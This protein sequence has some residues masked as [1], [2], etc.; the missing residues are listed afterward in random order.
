[1]IQTYVVLRN[2]FQR[3]EEE[4][5]CLE[6]YYC[7]NF[8]M[9]MSSILLTLP[10]LLKP[11]IR[12]SAHLHIFKYLKKGFDVCEINCPLHFSNRRNLY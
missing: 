11:F 10:S 9:I 3:A 1:M 8:S 5:V 12:Y 2:K 4:R 6:F 7:I